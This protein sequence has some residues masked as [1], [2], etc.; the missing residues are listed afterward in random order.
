MVF[1]SPLF[2]FLFLPIVLWVNMILPQKWNN[3]FLLLASLAFYAWGERVYIIVML[4]SIITNF[5]LGILIHNNQ[6]KGK[7]ILTI[8]V[9]LNLAALGYFKYANFVI[10]NINLLLKEIN[11][12]DSLPLIRDLTLP[13]GISFFTF[14]GLSYLVDVYRKETPAQ[15]SI[16]DLGLYV[17]L[18]PQLI[19][20]PIV[21]YHD[22][23]LQLKNRINLPDNFLIGVER[24]V[25]GLAKKMILANTFAYMADYIIPLRNEEVSSLLAWIG[26]LSYSLQIYFDF[27]G[28]SDMA[29]GLGRMMGFSFLENFNYPYISNSIKEFWR[30]W[31][32]SLSSWFRDYLYIPIGGSRG[33]LSRTYINLLIVF[34]VT[35][36]WHGASWNFVL[37]GMFHGIFL[38]SE[39]LFLEKILVRTSKIISHVYTLLVVITAWV[40]FRVE[41]FE[42]AIIY[43]KRMYLFVG[44]SQASQSHLDFILNPENIIIS[45]LGLFFVTPL[46]RKISSRV[47]QSSMLLKYGYVMFLFALLLVDMFYLGASTYNPFIYFRF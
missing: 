26:I 32:I 42:S 21:R 12:S 15:K 14:Q 7:I 43:I 36:L 41:N 45:I 2:L 4:L 35:G 20:G 3:L 10:S 27:S 29:I 38:I 25:I 47:H 22:V 28:Y 17:S 18:F 11:L 31:H 46:S 33:K 34:F 9:L 40:F 39:K 24:F 8:G 1:S 5:I 44:N 30:R 16:I 37:W 19:A 23:A 6:K 13:I